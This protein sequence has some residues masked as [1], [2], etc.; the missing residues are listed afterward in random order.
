[1][2]NILKSTMKIVAS[3]MAL[4]TLF[5]LPACDDNPDEYV[6]TGGEPTVDYIR[7]PDALSSDSLL[8][9]AFMG[10]TIALIGENMTSVKE[11]W[12]NNVQATLN[13]SLIKSDVL[14]LSVPSTIPTNVTNKIY[15][16]NKNKDTVTYHFG[17]DVPSPIL[18]TLTCE[19][20]NA[21]DIITINGNYFLSVA[22]SDVPEVYFTPNIKAEVVSYTLTQLNVKVPAAATEGPITMKSRYGSTRSTFRFRDS[23]GMILDWDNTNAS[24]GWRSGVIANTNPTGITGNY[25]RFT[26][27]MKGGAG[28]TW[29]EDAFAFNLW[30]TSN[31]R[32]EGDLF[33]IPVENAVLK[34]EVNV[35]QAW[36]AGALQMIF[37][38]WS[39]SGTN[40]YVGDATY[41][42][43]LWIPW[44]GSGSYT[45]NGWIT[46]SIPLKNFKYNASGAEVGKLTAGNCGGL[47]FFVFNGGVKGTDCTPNICIDN[48]RVVPAE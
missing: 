43:G 6:I 21:G 25:V 38:S 19:Y 11:V 47:T 39:T 18:N 29:N 22:G 9:H 14:I 1:M 12:F 26:G 8:T 20:A 41:P 37:T 30:G 7:L 3:A 42:R 46:V 40:G 15:L 28:E 23:R 33:S 4:L 34:F 35:T 13:S 2:K 36:S 24:G 48:I 10:T 5:A 45:T 44:E 16:I 31:G 27:T 17:V 32:P